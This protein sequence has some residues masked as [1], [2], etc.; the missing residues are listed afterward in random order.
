MH[1]LPPLPSPLP[2][3]R[4]ADAHRVYV[5]QHRGAGGAAVNAPTSSG[6]CQLNNGSPP[7]TNLQNSI[8]S[9]SHRVFCF[10]HIID[11]LQLY[12]HRGGALALLEIKITTQRK[13]RDCGILSCSFSKSML[14]VH[15]FLQI[16]IC[17]CWIKMIILEPTQHNWINYWLK[18]TD[19]KKRP[20]VKVQN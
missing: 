18:N 5:L 20:N 12:P 1:L 4:A 16:V 13:T 17:V 7:Q 19:V 3:P 8:A 9:E 10:A 6:H 11:L 14:F 15:C 2:R